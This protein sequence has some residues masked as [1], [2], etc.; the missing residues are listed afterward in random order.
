MNTKAIGELSEGVILAHLLQMGWAISLPF[1]NN[2]RY[3]LIADTSGKL[4]KLQCKT[5]HFHKGCAVFAT[6]SKNGFTNE[7]KCYK[8]QI[9][10]FV[11]YYPPTK[12]VYL[13]PVEV[14]AS[15]A[16]YLRLDPL[17]P[18]APKSTVHWAKDYELLI[19][20]VTGC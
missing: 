6:A 8:G 16:M 7:R 9:D 11:V 18:N 10:A 14:A 2:Q 3:D 1:G 17:K 13:V 12:S 4:L 19:T 20:A 15:T 5:A